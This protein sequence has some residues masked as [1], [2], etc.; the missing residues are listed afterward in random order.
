MNNNKSITAGRH[1][2][3]L[4]KVYLKQACDHVIH[5]KQQLA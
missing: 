4:Q 5:C 2:I 3:C 1:Q